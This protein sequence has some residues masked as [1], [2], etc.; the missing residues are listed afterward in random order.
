MRESRLTAVPGAIPSQ[1]VRSKWRSSG[2]PCMEFRV[3]PGHFAA[4]SVL[5]DL[6]V[7]PTCRFHT[8]IRLSNHPGAT[9]FFV[10]NHYWKLSA[11]QR[12]QVPK[13]G[14]TCGESPTMHLQSSVIVGSGLHQISPTSRRVSS[15]I[16]THAVT[17]KCTI[18][19]RW[20]R[21]VRKFASDI[22]WQSHRFKDLHQ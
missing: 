19:V 11:S 13:E 9:S 14:K 6:Q 7:L 5:T 12:L 22:F 16:G 18:D 15:E 8:L 4:M 21:A 10:T 20:L 17:S 1:P 3:I 2:N